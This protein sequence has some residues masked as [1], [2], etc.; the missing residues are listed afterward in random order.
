MIQVMLV[1]DQAIVREGIKA[2]LAP[3]TDIN[4]ASQASS[5]QDALDQLA[6]VAVDVVLLD[7]R[8]PGMDGLT[9]LVEIKRRHP[10][11]SVIMVT[12][13]DDTDYL[14]RAISSGANG[15]VLK[16]ASRDLLVEAVRLAAEGGSIVSPTLMP[17]LLA[18]MREMLGADMLVATPADVEVSLSPRELQVLELVADGLTN[19]QIAAEL[20]LSPTTIKTHVQNVLQKLNV[21]DRTQAAVHAVRSGLIL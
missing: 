9:A 3:E 15:Y 13:Y 17:P 2:M 18:E 20:I 6:S 1:D 16:D 14:L 4:I 7:V 11:L 12:L 10:R 5:G 8:M 19:Q 21:S